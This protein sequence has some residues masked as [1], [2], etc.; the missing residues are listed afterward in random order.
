MHEQVV[1]ES[2]ISEWA[3]IAMYTTIIITILLLLLSPPLLLSSCL[4]TVT[5]PAVCLSITFAWFLLM[6]EVMF[7]YAA[8]IKNDNFVTLITSSRKSVR[9]LPGCL[10]LHPSMGHNLLQSL[11]IV[12]SCVNHVPW[13][14]TEE[15]YLYK[16]NSDILACPDWNWWSV[17]E[18]HISQLE[19]QDSNPGCDRGGGRCTPLMRSVGS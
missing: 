10:W 1:T 9:W 13:K 7:V 14:P 11:H 15:R 8:V 17:R 4:S 2:W 3:N 6:Y 16:L 18:M 12:K 19:G 5:S